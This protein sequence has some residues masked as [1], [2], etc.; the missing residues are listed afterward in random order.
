[1]REEQKDGHTANEDVR[2]VVERISCVEHCLNT[3]GA[4]A[5]KTTIMR[6]SL[7]A[8]FEDHETQ[9]HALRKALET[10]QPGMAE[11]QIT[12]GGL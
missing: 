8:K 3:L 5:T 11:V 12:I 10:Q 9:I 7:G 4:N 1:M 2:A 6:D